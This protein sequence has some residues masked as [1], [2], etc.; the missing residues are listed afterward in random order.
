MVSAVVRAAQSFLARSRFALAAIA[1][2]GAAAG[3]LEAQDTPVSVVRVEEDWEL[4]VSQPDV[5]VDAPQV[6]VV[7][8]P[9][10]HLDGLYAAFELN[11]Q[12]QPTFAA[13]GMQLQLWNGEQP[14]VSKKHKQGIF[15]QHDNEVVTWTQEMRLQDGVLTFVVKNG[16]STSWGAFGGPLPSSVTTTLSNLNGYNPLVSVNESGPGFASNRVTSLTLKKVRLHLSNGAYVDDDTPK[17]AY[18]KQ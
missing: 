4:V 7:S 6:T 3:P 10:G 15:L 17:V 12:S 13:G 18:P 5:V 1:L 11:H 16:N 14:V 2:V 8:S 9:V